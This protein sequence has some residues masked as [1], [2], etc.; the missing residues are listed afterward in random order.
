[1]RKLSRWTESDPFYH[2]PRWLK[3]RQSVLR[4]DHYQCQQSKRTKMIPDEAVIVHHVLPR[5]V[6]PEYQW[7]PWNLISLSTHAHNQ[8]HD[9][10]TDHLTD[11]G[12]QWA[13]RVAR[14]QGLDLEKIEERL[15][16]WQ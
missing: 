6:F 1:M 15:S 2:S 16:H 14:R 11:L 3:L 9:R 4:R 7:Q 13:V 5:E 12:M 10:E 8:M